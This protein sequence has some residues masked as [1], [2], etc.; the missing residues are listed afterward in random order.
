MSTDFIDKL[1]EPPED[2]SDDEIRIWKEYG[3]KLI[4][5]GE[6]SEENIKDLESLVFWEFHKNS[7]L[8]NLNGGLTKNQ[9]LLLKGAK[10]KLHT[11]VLLSN[12]KA[13]QDEINEL[14][15]NLGF[16]AESPQYISNTPLIPD[17]AYR[18]MPQLLRSCCVRIKNSRKKDSFLL[19]SLPVLAFHLDNI[20]FEHTEG[21]FTPTIKSFLL[22]SH[23][24]VNFYA[25]KSIDLA[26]VLEKQCMRNDNVLK[27]PIISSSADLSSVYKIMVANKG[28]AILFDE[29]YR[30]IRS[31]KDYQTEVFRNLVVSSF[32]EKQVSLPNDQNE[33]VTVIP[34]LCMSQCA[35][36]D[37]L[38]DIVELFGEEYLNYFL[39]YLHDESPDW[40]S[41]RPTDESRQLL[42]EI[43]ALSGEMYRLNKMCM[44]R[45]QSLMVDLTYSQWQM[46]DDTFQEKISIIEDLGLVQQLNG[47]L[48]HLSVYV[49]KM[50]VLFRMI[51][52]LEEETDVQNAETLTARDEDVVASLWIIDTLLKHSVRI[53]QNLPAMKENIRGDRYTR[54]YD[55]LP[56]I[57]DTS[58]ALDFASKISLPARTANRYLSTYL[59]NNYLNKLRKG[60]YYK[61]EL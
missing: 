58:Q 45:E 12:Y 5:K 17:E 7:T 16:Q 51:R 36:I 20:H 39:F 29:K 56:I 33:K 48:V 47:M 31:G 6:L 24:I 8:L 55:V 25:R 3:F 19:Y 18:N 10:Q 53:Y 54:F 61:R 22:N 15:L 2:F 26:S 28:K 43:E 44:N 4:S 59:E 30:L 52:S 38:K 21:T 37:D 1:P 49:V 9:L 41:A 27:H 40:E 42:Q 13:V 34:K 46:I 60:V 11:S 57:F 32:R 14:R 35:S 23:G 50:A